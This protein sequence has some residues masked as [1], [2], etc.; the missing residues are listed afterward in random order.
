MKKY[1]T[2]KHPTIAA[3]INEAFIFD[4]EADAVDRIITLNQYFIFSVKHQEKKYGVNDVLWIRGYSINENDK[5]DGFLGNFAKIDLKKKGFNFT[6]FCT[7]ILVPLKNHPMRERP[8]MSHPDWGHPFL[9]ELKSEKEELISN[10]LGKL[11]DKMLKFYGEYKDNSIPVYFE[12]VKEKGI[13]KLLTLVWSNNKEEKKSPIRR[14]VIEI[15]QDLNHNYKIIWRYNEKTAQTQNINEFNPKIRIDRSKEIKIILDKI[16]HLETPVSC[17]LNAVLNDLTQRSANHAPPALYH[18]TDVGAILG[19]VKDKRIWMSDI[20]FMN[21]PS[22]LHYGEYTVAH[23]GFRQFAEHNT[24]YVSELIEKC[25]TKADNTAIFTSKIR[26]HIF[27]FSLSSKRDAITHWRE[28]AQRGK[29]YCLELKSKNLFALSDNSLGLYRVRYHLSDQT[30]VYLQF[31]EEIQRSLL[32]KNDLGEI[33]NEILSDHISI[34]LSIISSIM[35]NMQY[36]SE[37]EWRILNIRPRDDIAEIKFSAR[38]FAIKPYVDL[39]LN[40]LIRNEEVGEY[41]NPIKSIMAGPALEK[42]AT[43]SLELLISQIKE[44]GIS[45]NCSAIP[46]RD[47]I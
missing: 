41:N 37:S 43:Y 44:N 47:L 33:S 9:R 14:I 10:D 20:R 45:I 6:L 12:G 4:S 34:G 39:D 23:E 38:P 7:K 35:K 19:I 27:A 36:E 18:Y 40:E 42:I 25:L 16:F 29:G 5:T 31:F 32:N 2:I 17:A 8:K 11:Q 28:Y 1:A 22:E 24:G 26:P 46:L 21:D 13:M 30:E 15:K 3:V